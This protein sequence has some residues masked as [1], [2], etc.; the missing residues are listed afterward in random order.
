MKASKY[1]KTRTVNVINQEWH[2][3]GTVT[4]TIYKSGWKKSYSF[5]VKNYGKK[6]EHIIED[7]E[8]TESI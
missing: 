3:N 7:E 4:V 6:N 1:L 5:K 2:Q 8:I